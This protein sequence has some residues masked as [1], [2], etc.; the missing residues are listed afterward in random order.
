LL[1]S[2]ILCVSAGC[3]FEFGAN[4]SKFYENNFVFAIYLNFDIYAI[5]D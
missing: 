1:E 4:D 5:L 2:L 3:S